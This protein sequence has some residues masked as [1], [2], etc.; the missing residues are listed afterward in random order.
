MAVI[1]IMI[2]ITEVQ[3]Q[4][5]L[6]PFAG[7]VWWKEAVEWGSIGTAFVL[8]EI[9]LKNMPAWPSD[10]VLPTDFRFWSENETRAEDIK[11][12]YFYDAGLALGAAILLVPDSNG[13]L[14]HSSYR[15]F[16]GFFEANLSLI[17]LVTA[18]V[19]HTL[20]KYRP[21]WQQTV[22]EGGKVKASDSMSF[23]APDAASAFGMAAYAGLYVFNNLGTGED[24]EMAWKL[25]VILGLGG[26]AFYVSCNVIWSHG[27]D[28]ID[29]AAGAV[30]GT[31]LSVLVYGL[32]ENWF[33]EYYEE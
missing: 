25:P 1:I 28:P 30:A 26:L 12:K 20:P 21:S 15:H 8:S 27:G 13:F 11:T 24:C 4:Q 18:L 23:W 3:A 32:H 17:P 7:T 5:G 31:L 14:S 16:K 9:V 29:V 22:D 6:D 33:G 19:R 10:P 2:S